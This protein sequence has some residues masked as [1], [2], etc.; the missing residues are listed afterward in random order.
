M[1]VAVIIPIYNTSRYL[2]KC[3][4]SV[5]KQTYQDFLVILVNDGSLDDSLDI[6]LD[7]F[8]Q[9]RRF[10]VIDK[11]NGGQSSARNVALDFIRN[12]GVL[13]SKKVKKIWRYFEEYTCDAL[14]FL[15]SDDWI[16]EKC[17]ELCVQEMINSSADIVVHDWLTIDEKGKEKNY[18]FFQNFLSLP[19]ERVEM[20]KNQF[21]ERRKKGFAGFACNSLYGY[22]IFGHQECRFLE[23]VIFEDT[24]SYLIFFSFARKIVYIPHILYFVFE[25]N[26]STMRYDQKS[27]S[28]TYF[29]DYQKRNFLGFRDPYMM[30]L[31]HVGY[32]FLKMA[33]EVENFSKNVEIDKKTKKQLKRGMRDLARSGL[34]CLVPISKEK[35]DPKQCCL[36]MKNIAK[37]T[38]DWKMIL[39]C[40]MPLLVANA[41]RARQFLV[42]K[43]SKVL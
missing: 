12:N 42:K 19:R 13:D 39:G 1:K 32:S 30:Y 20:D 26:N 35:H 2:R 40:K 41:W 33:I 15:D 11:Q 29:S 5:L 17:L 10:V 31:Y 43:L 16:E 7:Y 24:L 37:K 6:C 23:G 36:M 34:V 28:M 38:L 22:E 25:R 9:D 14:H 21:F 18:F 8:Q 3:I 4:D 27:A